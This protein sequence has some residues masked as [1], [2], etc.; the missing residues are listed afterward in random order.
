MLPILSTILAFA[1]IAFH[2]INEI[3]YPIPYTS[4]EIAKMRQNYPNDELKVQTLIN[5]RYQE[6]YNSLKEDF[7]FQQQKTGISRISINNQTGTSV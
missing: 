6:A 5:E 1:G 4:I 7:N 3:N 2:K